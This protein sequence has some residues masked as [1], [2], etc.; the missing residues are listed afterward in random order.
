M[1]KAKKLLFLFGIIT[2]CLQVSAN[3]QTPAT[4]KAIKESASADF[5]LLLVSEDGRE[6]KINAADLAKLKRQ[7]IKTSDH[8]KAAV[9][10]GFALVEVLK[11]AGFEFGDALRGKRLANFLLVEAADN[12]RAVFALPELDPAF[13]DKIVLLADK[14][15]GAPLAKT[16][17]QLRLVVPDEKKAARWVRQVTKL[18]ILRAE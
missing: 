7:T 15:D 2:I 9:F 14:R 13:T 11:L 12:Y 4:P 3:G 1:K 6:V 16:E 10:E 18:R 8:G 17:G 5:S